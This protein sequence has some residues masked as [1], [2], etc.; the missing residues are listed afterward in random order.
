MN[1]GSIIR[2]KKITLLNMKKQPQKAPRN[3]CGDLIA[4]KN[5]FADIGICAHGYWPGMT[6]LADVISLPALPF[7]SAETGSE[8]LWKLYEMFPAIQKQFEES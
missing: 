3:I 4:V 7:K 5:G 1:Q 8:V 6:P 2:Y